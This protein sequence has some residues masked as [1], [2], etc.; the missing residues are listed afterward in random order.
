[1]TAMLGRLLSAACLLGPDPDSIDAILRTIAETTETTLHSERIDSFIHRAVQ[2]IGKSEHAFVIGKGD[3]FGVAQEAALKIKESSYIH[4][5]AFAAGELKHGAIALIE[6]GSPCLLFTTD[7]RHIR[8]TAS[9]A[10]EVRSRGGYTIGVGPGFES[11]ADLSLFL[12]LEGPA[13]AIAEVVIAQMLALQLAIHR[14]LDPD[15]PRNLAKSVTV[16]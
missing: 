4:A 7:R 15:F 16:K 9:A 11:V 2:V 3:A 10:Q 1:M 5:E 12:G 14:N 13:L 6:Q 8:D